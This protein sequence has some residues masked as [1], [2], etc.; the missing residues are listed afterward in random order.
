MDT[1][2]PSLSYSTVGH[3]GRDKLVY[4]TQVSDLKKVEEEEEE[5]LDLCY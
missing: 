5:D 1:Y 2:V 3:W 4:K